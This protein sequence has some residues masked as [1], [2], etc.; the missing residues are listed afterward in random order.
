HEL[1]A[2]TRLGLDD[3]PADPT[4]DAALRA[5]QAEAQAMV[6]RYGGFDEADAVV[7]SN[8]DDFP[9]RALRYHHFEW[10]NAATRRFLRRQAAAEK[11]FFLY[12]A[13]TAIHGPAHQ[14][15]LHQ[16][17]IYTPGG[18]DSSLAVHRTERAALAASLEG[19]PPHEQHLRTGMSQL[20]GHV[21]AVVEALKAHGLW[22]HTLVIFMADHNTEPAKATCYQ[23]GVHVPL[24]VA[25][26]GV[27]QGTTEALVQSVDLLP[28]L[29]QRLDLPLPAGTLDG[30]AFGPTLDAPGTPA[31]DIAYF[32]AGYARAVTDGRYTYQTFRLPQ[33]VQDSLQAL[34]EP[35]APNYLNTFKQ[36][37]SQIALEAYPGYFDP[38]Q[39]YDLETDPYQQENRYGD[40]EL[41]PVQARLRQALQAQ[42]ARFDHPYPLTDT[43]F[44][45]TPAYE[46]MKARTRA[47]GTTYIGWWKR[48][49]RDKMWPPEP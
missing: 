2:T 18:I 12:V 41:I 40:P 9:V 48:D 5:H 23:K 37:H 8:Y 6:R 27:S 4:V 33:V 29:A 3:D 44:F 13:T 25:G 39:L 46:E 10:V 14:S 15:V 11:P 42:L 47:I 38:D 26:P 49:H 7:W 45:Y 30:R 16:D 17:P 36:A 35:F 34:P 21:G 28:T 32:E 24:I 22:E 19:L 20:D 1:A 43:A 31:R